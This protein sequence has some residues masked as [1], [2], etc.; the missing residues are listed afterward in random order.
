MK[1]TEYLLFLAVML[2][3]ILVLVA[4]LVSIAHPAPPPATQAPETTV[5]SAG[6]YPADR[7]EEWDVRL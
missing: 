1:I 3:T 6:L 4:A 2:P 5:S 7:L